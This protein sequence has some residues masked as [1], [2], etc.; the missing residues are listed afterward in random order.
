MAHGVTSPHAREQTAPARSRL[1]GT[2]ELRHRSRPVP[3]EASGELLGVAAADL[4]LLG[5]EFLASRA[6]QQEDASADT[7]RERGPSQ[8]FALFANSPGHQR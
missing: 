4:Q 7:T 5:V 6:S 1:L 2:S 8:R 3:F